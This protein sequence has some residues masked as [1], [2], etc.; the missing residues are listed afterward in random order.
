M[1]SY[2][3]DPCGR[4]LAVLACQ[5][6]DNGRRFRRALRIPVGVPVRDDDNQVRFLFLHRCCLDADHHIGSAAALKLDT[7][8][9]ADTLNRMDFSV[10][11]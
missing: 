5:Y 6:S 9:V 8:R 11:A 1:H 4:R 10:H 7:V 3:M 2:A